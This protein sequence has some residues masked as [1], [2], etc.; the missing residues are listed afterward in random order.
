MFVSECIAAGSEMPMSVN[1]A[2][3]LTLDCSNSRFLVKLMLTLTA[4]GF[5]L[6]DRDRLKV[7]S[8]STIAG[9]EPSKEG[10]DDA[11]DFGAFPFGCELDASRLSRFARREPEPARVGTALLTSSSPAWLLGR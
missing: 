5:M 10:L 7:L 1:V 4:R 9:R 3:E 2:V 6:T 11:G 8:R